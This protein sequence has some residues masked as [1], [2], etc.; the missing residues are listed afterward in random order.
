[1][2]PLL[3]LRKNSIH[4]PMLLGIVTGLMLVMALTTPASAALVT[5]TD[6]NSVV[7]IDTQTQAGVYDWYVGGI[8]NMHQQW[9]WFR[10]GNSGPEQSLDTLV[11][12]PATDM[13]LSDG[14]FNPGDDRLSLRYTDQAGRFEIF[15]DYTLTG[16]QNGSGTSDLIETVRVHSLQR[17]GNLD[18]HFFQYSDFDLNEGTFDSSVEVLNANTVRQTDGLTIAET[19]ASPAPSR[20][21][22]NYYDIT[23][24]A[25]NDGVATDLN[26]NAGPLFDDDLTWAFQWDFNLAPG[27]SFIISKDKH[28]DHV[29]PEPSSVALLVLGAVGTGLGAWRKR[30]SSR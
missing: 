19:V 5:L 9:F 1:M 14:N 25:L 13:I 20:Y 21:E 7:N 15:V 4:H 28:L 18:F 26:Q 6:S 29:V 8:D 10:I 16:G 27:G 24:T 11:H 3:E 22:V 12:N 2:F 23:L 30:R 17:T